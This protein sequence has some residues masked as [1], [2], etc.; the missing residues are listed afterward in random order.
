[1]MV[2]WDF[3]VALVK[4]TNQPVPHQLDHLL[5]MGY[6]VSEISEMNKIV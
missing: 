6:F 5:V 1:M 3:V 2:S 4:E